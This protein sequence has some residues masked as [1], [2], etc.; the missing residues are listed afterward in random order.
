MFKQFGLLEEVT[1]SDLIDLPSKCREDYLEIAKY[2][3]KGDAYDFVYEY[4]RVNDD[5]YVSRD[6]D[7]YTLYET[8]RKATDY[9]DGQFI[10]MRETS[11]HTVSVYRP[12]AVLL[13]GDDKQCKLN[14]ITQS[15]VRVLGT[16]CFVLELD[17]DSLGKL[18]QLFVKHGIVT[19]RLTGKDMVSKIP[20]I[21]TMYQNIQ[22]ET[23]RYGLQNIL[24]NKHDN[25]DY[26]VQLTEDLSGCEEMV[27][28]EYWNGNIVTV[29]PYKD[30]MN[31]IR[32]LH[33]E[34]V[35]LDAE[36]VS[37][38][39][40]NRILPLLQYKNRNMRLQLNIDDVLYNL[41][42]HTDEVVDCLD[43]DVQEL[44]ALL[45]VVSFDSQLEEELEQ[46][47]DEYGGSGYFKY[48]L[49][50]YNMYI[51]CSFVD[52][53]FGDMVSASRYGNEVTLYFKRREA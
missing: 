33:K 13:G 5:Y 10:N 48:S 50:G 32:V 28:T 47:S 35:Y 19:L 14:L 41:V 53:Y 27:C 11:G 22:I 38:Q 29:R 23:D 31:A 49:N 45:T 34:Y 51:A 20:F 2:I 9:V 12:C 26:F 1:M 24:K 3:E 25:I 36:L 30:V 46:L 7:F 6:F 39:D 42:E 44:P 16:E 43:E 37:V 8:T 18:K 15:T 52:E 21:H 17:T 4:K 40:F